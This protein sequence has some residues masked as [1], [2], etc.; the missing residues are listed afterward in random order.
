MKTKETFKLTDHLTVDEFFIDKKQANQIASEMDEA[1]DN[2]VVYNH[3]HDFLDKETELGYLIYRF[4]KHYKWSNM[5]LSKSKNGYFFLVTDRKMDRFQV[6]FKG[7]KSISSI[8]NS[9]FD[10][11]KNLIREDNDDE[12]AFENFE[13]FKTWYENEYD[14]KVS[15]CQETKNC[16]YFE[17][18]E[19][20]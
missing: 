15:R 8:L 19:A 11:Y 13:D 1:N 20:F 9:F 3:G 5:S 14:T 6:L 10:E 17:E 4:R 2:I 12:T 16:I 7:S 18:I